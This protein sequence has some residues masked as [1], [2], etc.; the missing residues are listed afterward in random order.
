MVNAINREQF[1]SNCKIIPEIETLC[2]EKDT[3]HRGG[4]HRNP[5]FSG[6]ECN[7]TGSG[8]RRLPKREQRGVHLIHAPLPPSTT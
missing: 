3:G 6:N 7:V 2:S 1:L 5:D 4:D 8:D